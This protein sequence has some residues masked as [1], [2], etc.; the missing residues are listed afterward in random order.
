MSFY[1]ILFY[2]WK[3]QTKQ[4]REQGDKEGEENKEKEVNIFIEHSFCY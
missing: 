1:F 2:F 4:R 3:K